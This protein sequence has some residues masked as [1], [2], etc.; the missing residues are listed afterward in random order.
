MRHQSFGIKKHY[1]S[2]TL[3]VNLILFISVLLGLCYGVSKLN[4][5][6]Q[7]QQFI[8]AQKAVVRAA[9][10]CYALEGAYPKNLSYLKE[11]YSLMVDEE[12]YFVDYRWIGSNLMPDI[13]VLSKNTSFV[14]ESKNE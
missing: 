11:N 8:V 14:E 7:E 12:Q 2:K 5:V 9:V 10:Q 13:T 4:T 1:I 3:L 6:S